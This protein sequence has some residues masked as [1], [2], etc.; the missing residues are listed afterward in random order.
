MAGE[1]ITFE[2]LSTGAPELG[3]QFKSVA[4]NSVLAARGARLL[5]DSLRAEQKSADASARASL[6]LARADAILE[7]A[8]HGLRD[9]ALEAEFALRRQAESERKAGRDAETAAPGISRLGRALASLQHKG[10]SP[11]LGGALLALPALASIGGVGAAAAIGAGGAF[12]TAGAGLAAYGIVAKSVLSE[13]AKAA[14]AVT[15]AQGAYNAALAAGVKPAKAYRAEQL[16]IA[17]AYA[18]MSP[19]QI[20]LSKEL[21]AVSAAWGKFK[22]SVTPLIAGS[23]QPWL[24]GVSGALAD[25]KLIITPMAGAV[26]DLGGEFSALAGSGAMQAFS[27]WLGR[28][29][30]II[31]GT[32]GEAVVQFIDGLVTL[33]PKFT[34]LMTGA[35]SAVGRWA[36]SFDTWAGSKKASAEITAFLSWF[37]QNGKTVGSFLRSVGAALKTLTPGLTSGGQLELKLITGFMNW[38]AKL[39]KGIAAPLAEA[40]G[41]ALILNKLGGGRVISFLLTG[42]LGGIFAKGGIA[43]GAEAAA[44]GAAAGGLLGRLLPGARLLGAG[45]FGVTL[46]VTVLSSIK[47]GPGGKNWWNNPFGA[48]PKSKDPAKQGIST[49]AGLGDAIKRWGADMARWF[50][51]L[52]KTW[53]GNFLGG[54]TAAWKNVSGWFAGIGR[55]IGGFFAAAGSWLLRHGEDVITGLWSG[56]KGA[57]ASVSGWFGGLPGKVGGF[58]A[59]AG[60]WLAA[61]GANII[62]GLLAGIKS[63]WSTVVSWFAGLPSKILHALGIHSPPDWAVSAGSHIMGGLLKGIAHGASDVKGFFLGIAKDVSGP[64]KSVWSGL[65]AAGKDVWHFLFGGGGGGGGGGGSASAAQAYAK[66]ILGAYGWGPAQMGPLIRL[67]NSESGWRWNAKNPASGAYGIPQALPASKMASAGADWRT[68][69]KTQVRWGE[70][71]IKSVYGTPANAW[72]KWQSR[73][74]HWYGGGLDAM[75]TSPTIIGVGERGPERVM[76]TPT[77][78]GG[79]GGD[80]GQLAARLDRLSAQMAELIGVTAAVPART[81]QHVAGAVSGAAA[82]AS[83]RMRYPRG[84]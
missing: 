24:K 65:A 40:A 52:G 4:D 36:A 70:G 57:W 59:T 42:S 29:G 60:R 1:S 5:S 13:S 62:N 37:K 68:S 79:G 28:T 76:V 16:A 43:A 34:P 64:F 18:G 3:R 55:N 32:L 73:S 77:R 83:F 21:G 26:R 78:G 49:W 38:V 31:A 14:Q 17:K 7:E 20:A 25:L 12:A 75:F 81:G 61:G 22:E 72:A 30:A 35:A 69:Y 45:V 63:V 6:S 39:P 84:R 54:L 23:L 82:D 46:A 19:Q 47:S 48:D 80:V 51:G 44:G 33:L 10:P 8:E 27:A 53:L 50:A 56:L 11:L 41:A 2:F 9:G 66:S 67:W 71:Y 58:F 74:P 15:K